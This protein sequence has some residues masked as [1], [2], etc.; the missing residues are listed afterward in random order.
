MTII[1]GIKV[2]IRRDYAAQSPINP[3]DIQD[4]TDQEGRVVGP[5]KTKHIG[6][7]RWKVRFA[8]DKLR[9]F[10]EDQLVIVDRNHLVTLIVEGEP[11]T[12]YGPFTEKEADH[13]VGMEQ[14]Y[15]KALQPE[16]PFVWPDQETVYLIH[17][18][19]NPYTKSPSALHSETTKQ[20]S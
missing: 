9:H 20:S 10:D 7:K 6:V 4:R 1:K 14:R 12:T 15:A 17:E 5:S 16:R 3:F 13:W 18:M 8:D 11:N 2:S 19:E